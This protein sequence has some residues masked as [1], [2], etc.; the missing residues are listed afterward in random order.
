MKNLLL[1][2]RDVRFVLFEQLELEKLAGREAFSG[3]SRDDY[4]M[5][6]DTAEKLALNVMEPLNKTG[7][8]QGC[9]YEN[10]EVFV[11]AGFHGAHRRI[12]E[13]GW[14]CMAEDPGVGGQGL[15]YCLTVA[16]SELLTAANGS[17]AGYSLLSH[18]VAKMIEEF[19]EDRQKKE[20]MRPI[21]EGSFCGTMCLTE[22][23]AGSDVGAV[24]TRAVP[25]PDGSYSITGSKIFITNGNHDLA[26]NIVHAVLARIEGDPPG[27]RGLSLFLVPK[28][29]DGAGGSREPNDVIC[30]G[31]EHKMGIHGS[32]TCSLSFGDSG[33]CRGCLLG[34]PRQGIAIMFR[35]M[36]E[37]RIG[38]GIQANALAS[39]AYLN[40]A[41]YARERVQG[42]H[43][44]MS[45][46]ED[47]PRVPIIQ[48]PDVRRMLAGM[49]AC[50]E[51]GR[52][53]L[54][55]AAHCLDMK[56]NASGGDEK[57]LWQGYLELLTPVVKAYL[58]DQGFEVCAQ[59][60]Q[61]LGGYGY[62]AEY[63]LEQHLRDIKIT[64]IYEGTNG[65]QALDLFGRKLGMKGGQVFMSFLALVDEAV[66]RAAAIPELK[67]Y[68]DA[69]AEAR[70]TLAETAMT[71]AGRARGPEFLA[72][73][74]A[75]TPFLE[76]F[77]DV[78]MAWLLLWQAAVALEKIG[79][80]AGS[81]EAGASG[82]TP[83]PAAGDPDRAFY[84]GKIGAARF[85]IGSLL[86]RMH[87]KARQVLSPE[88]GY[89]TMPEESF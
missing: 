34:K 40:A 2:M 38:V 47:A 23:Q 11:P 35:M 25:L 37:A 76:L 74:G 84:L 44:T 12:V 73:V 85:Y 7:D 27:T 8:R 61:V 21:Y 49:K 1:D 45:R 70:N 39:A 36:N 80:P 43:A 20:F 79:P 17:L 69:V 56:K 59:A 89:L 14:H 52:S 13:G 72:V 29:R 18:G 30:T 51:G 65:I 68:A 53:L 19:G 10:G 67:P 82:E 28:F 41:A 31:I 78:V 15:P 26:E 24:R 55:F 48:H 87:G 54:Y 71:L 63:P 9:R 5:V 83:A 58:A 42:P 3:Q 66:A 16:C 64:S 81:G 77:G 57:E 32:A 86:P 4:E 60:M 46:Q 62:T 6:L 75:A 50:V 88:S 22:P 33:N